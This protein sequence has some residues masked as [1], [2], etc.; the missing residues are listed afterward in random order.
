M[1]CSIAVYRS[2]GYSAIGSHRSDPA[3]VGTRKGDVI[4]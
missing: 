4:T 1:N 3:A 2:R